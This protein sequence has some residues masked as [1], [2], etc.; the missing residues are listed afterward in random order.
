ML[1]LCKTASLVCV[2]VISSLSAQDNFKLSVL[3]DFKGF[4]NRMYLRQYSNEAQAI[5]HVFSLLQRLDLYTY[6]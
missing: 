2:Y 4:C 1:E 5:L 3:L 6:L